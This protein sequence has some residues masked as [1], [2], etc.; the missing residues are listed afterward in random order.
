MK[1]KE[2][3]KKLPLSGISVLDLTNVLSGPFATLILADLGA[4]VIKVEKPLGDDSRNYGPFINNESSYFISLNRGKKSIVLDLKT[5]KDKKIFDKLLSKVDIL[6]DNFKPGILEKLGYS[7]KSLSKKYPNLIHSKISGFGETGPYKKFPAY[8]IIVQAMGGVMSITGNDKK[9]FVRVGSS[10]GDIVAG[11]FCVIGILSQLI[12]R[13]KNKLGSKLDLSML[14]CQ[15]AI[16]E[17]AIARFSVEKKIPEPLGTDHPT[18]SPFGVFKTKNGAITL[19]AGNNKIFK[20]LCDAIEYK[21]LN[22]DILFSTN[23][24]RNKNLKL[25]K[26]QI[27]SKLKNK[28]S[29]FW[30]N[31][32]RKNDIP[33]APIN[34][35]KNIVEDPHLKER[36]MVLDYR[37]N[38]FNSLKVTGNPLKFNFLKEKKKPKK[39]PELNE[40]RDEI[41]K[42]FG[43]I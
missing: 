17:N 22:Y 15:I 9:N 27:E 33:C 2:E 3:N 11:L 40:N 10:I 35:I 25:L 6:V 13:S 16:L 38:K 26:I 12:W 31:K 37:Y 8:D 19:A 18:I 43:I 4:N 30:I 39:S 24:K 23:K 34:N 1:K 41:L 21:K 14:D 5:K 7:W 32:L 42:F 36:K 28:K 20:K 29:E